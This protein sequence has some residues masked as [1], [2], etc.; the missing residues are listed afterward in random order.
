ML[1]QPPKLFVNLAVD[2][3]GRSVE[4]FTGLGFSFD[5]R[6]TDATATCMVL[7]EES[8]VMLLT[9]QKFGEF[10]SKEIVDSSRGTEA[11]LALSASSRE[12]VDAFA[13]KALASGGSPAKD[14]L[15]YGFMYSRSFQDPDGHLWE[16]F[17]IDQAAAEHGPPD[18]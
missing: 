13:D 10:T 1:T 2:D 3:L 9:R 8:F 17:W 4:F 11:I 15:E 16:I 5:Q 7:S 6:F 18:M 12:E 14:P